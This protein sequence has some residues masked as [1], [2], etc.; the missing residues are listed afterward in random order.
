M[1]IWNSST[2]REDMKA[3]LSAI[4]IES[5][6]GKRILVT[7][8]TGLICSAIVD[9]LL[10]CN[11]ESGAAIEIYAAGRDREK[12]VKRF[13][14]GLKNGLIPVIYDATNAVDFDFAVDY[15]IHGASN[16]SPDKY[17]SEPVDTMLA[18][19]LGISN[20]LEYAKSCGVEKTVYISSSEV[21]GVLTHGKPLCEDDYLSP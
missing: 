9:L 7:G 1:S 3:A 6:R 8:A 2:Y 16:A 17:V 11:L 14:H 13:A 20:L 18:N 5:L 21:Y 19:V 15:I 4:D 12:I 10:C